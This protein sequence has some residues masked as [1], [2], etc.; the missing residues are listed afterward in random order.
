M[1]EVR[2]AVSNCS[3][4]GQNNYCQARAIVVQPDAQGFSNLTDES[5][6]NAVLEGTQMESAASNSVETC[7][8]TFQPK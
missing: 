4:W 5:Y 8:Q 2:C 3:F 7:C 1:P 6:Y